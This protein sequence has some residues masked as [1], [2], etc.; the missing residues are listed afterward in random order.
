MEEL[1][2]LLSS[3]CNSEEYP[4]VY[5]LHCKHFLCAAPSHC[6]SSNHS[7]PFDFL[8]AKEIFTSL[9][10]GS[11]TFWKVLPVLRRRPNNSG[12]VPTLMTWVD[13]SDSLDWTT[14]MDYC[15]GLTQTAIKCLFECRTGTHSAGYFPEV[16]PL[17]C[18]GIFPQVSRGQRSCAYLISLYKEIKEHLFSA[19]T[20][21]QPFWSIENR[22]SISRSCMT[23]VEAHHWN[24]LNMHVT[25]D[26][27]WC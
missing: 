21:L 3:C 17:A 10:T 23:R 26:L 6:H 9:L 20:K 7:L 16:A 2:D 15:T 27:H 12:E 8:C 14:G 5:S 13:V 24:L 19:E 18:W 4:C 11:M 25:F 22:N 1:G